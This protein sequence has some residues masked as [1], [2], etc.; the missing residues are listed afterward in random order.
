METALRSL[1]W[2]K[3][4]TATPGFTVALPAT[5]PN[6]ARHPKLPDVQET[7]GGVGVATLWP[8]SV[9]G[10]EP[11]RA[12]RGVGY[13]CNPVEMETQALALHPT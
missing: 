5:A 8:S 1:S 13:A 7:E 3:S 10:R 6:S 4:I 2:S 9:A 12:L 11:Q